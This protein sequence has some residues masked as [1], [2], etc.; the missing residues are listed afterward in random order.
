[1]E[2]T[3]N[4]QFYNYI[5]LRYV[6]KN[7]FR[8]I[9]RDYHLSEVLNVPCFFNV[10][11]NVVV[12]CDSFNHRSTNTILVLSGFRETRPQTRPQTLGGTLSNLLY[13]LL[14]I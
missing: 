13:S 4:R 7:R 14:S 11:F 8:Q 2:F 9:N 12:V 10:V 5:D 6:F 1:M 3:L